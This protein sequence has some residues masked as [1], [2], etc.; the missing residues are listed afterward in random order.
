MLPMASGKAKSQLARNNE[1]TSHSI[2]GGFANEP[3]DSSSRTRNSEGKPYN[4]IK[5]EALEKR[6]G[7]Q[8]GDTPAL[9]RQLY[10]FW[11]RM[12]LKDFNSNVYTEFRELAMRDASEEVPARCGLKHLLDF[13][14]KLL[15]DSEGQKPW[16]QD[17]AIPSIF[18]LHFQEALDFDR[19][20][21]ARTEAA[22]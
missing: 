10:R 22:I 8:P 18:Q 12:L 11:S 17:R 9:M 16:P 2:N 20:I 4:E 14:E 3:T 13:Y 15:L 19:S 7:A 6:S 21:D 5:R 1:L